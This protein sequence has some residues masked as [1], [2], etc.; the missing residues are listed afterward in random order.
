M[1]D[2][3]PGTAN[4]S[5][6]WPRWASLWAWGTCG[7]SLT[8]ARRMEEVSYWYLSKLL[9]TFTVTELKWSQVK[10]YL[11]LKAASHRYVECPN[12][13]FI[14]LLININGI[15]TFKRLF[16]FWLSLFLLCW[17]WNMSST[18]ASDLNIRYWA[19]LDKYWMD[20]HEIRCRYSNL[21]QDDL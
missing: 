7:A 10:I 5:T 18:P 14:F 4:C 6:S 21:S 8:C 19:I 17:F 11:F 15:R 3:P 20:C 2:A 12:F 1:T 9:I 13:H 16:N